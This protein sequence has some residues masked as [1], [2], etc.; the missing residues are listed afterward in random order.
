MQ[1]QI[2]YLFF[3]ILFFIVRRFR[4][5]TI[6]RAGRRFGWF[7]YRVIG[8]RKRLVLDNLRHAFPEKTA[9]EID[10]LALAA[11]RNLFTAYFEILALDTLSEEEIKRRVSFPDAGRMN[12]L[13]KQGK[14]LI[15][16]TGHYGNWELCSLSVAAHVKQRYTII[17]QKQRNPFINE[18]MTAMR[19][20]FGAKL[21]VMERG[22]RE[23][24]RALSNNEIVALIADQS[25]PE[26]GIYTNFFGR[27]ASTHQGPA[28]FQV[29]S[30]APMIV[31]MLIR[32]GEGQFRIELEEIDTQ[33]LS[34]TDAERMQ[35]ITD[36]HVASLERYIRRY[37]DHWL[38]MHKRWKHTDHYR[39]RQFEQKAGGV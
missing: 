14:G 2:E 16:L 4:F 11:Y 37:P 33:T 7:V 6:Q 17:V 21:V 15:V 22:L 27:P 8:L 38:W 23:S 18:F 19:S 32:E 25:G 12:E 1:N 28:V 31:V 36:R 5:R 3:R 35:Q 30:G 9:A 20:R 26:S 10:A 13:L 34:G 39:R 29:R 24:L